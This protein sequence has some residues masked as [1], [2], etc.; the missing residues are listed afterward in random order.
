M[1]DSVGHS[2]KI[3]ITNIS[4]KGIGFLIE[5]QSSL[6]TGDQIRAKFTLDNHARS[7][8]TKQ[9]LVKGVKDHY[10]GGQFL[11]ADK[12]DITLGFYLM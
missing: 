11:G 8:I 12:N 2:G 4:K 5:G 10:A 7:A 9:I 1:S 3:R 6:K